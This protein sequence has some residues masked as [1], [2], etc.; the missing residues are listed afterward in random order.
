MGC[1]SSNG[2]GPLGTGTADGECKLGYGYSKWGKVLL[3]DRQHITVATWQGLC[4]VEGKGGLRLY[5]PQR[6][7]KHFD[8]LVQAGKAGESDATKMGNV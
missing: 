4:Q 5:N 8:G 6:L 2:K 1:C 7:T 3:Q